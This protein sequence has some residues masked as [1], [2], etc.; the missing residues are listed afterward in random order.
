M[1]ENAL[2]SAGSGEEETSH[3]KEYAKAAVIALALALFIRTF[4][5][6][7]FKIP[8][9]SMMETLLVGDHLLVNKM[10]PRFSTPERGDILVFRYPLDHSRDFV[11]RVVGLPGETLEM[12]RN[13]VY[14]NGRPL[15]EPYAIYQTSGFGNHFGPITVP[16]GHL[17]MMGDNRDNSQDSRV[18]GTLD[19]DEIRGKAFIIHWSW[20]EN[21]FGVRWN[22]L[23]K[24]L[25]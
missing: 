15:D 7:A 12:V 2:N 5:V 3:W 9:E 13:T 8:S 19:M 18:W 25:E 6:Q 23:G 17:F 14:I 20:R 22:R 11:K 24:L 4:V 10:A 1:S 21:S 16:D